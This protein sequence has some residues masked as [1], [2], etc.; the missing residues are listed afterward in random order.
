MECHQTVGVL[1]DWRGAPPRACLK[2]QVPSR[3]GRYQKHRPSRTCLPWRV[4]AKFWKACDGPPSPGSPLPG[5][6]HPPQ[7]P[8]PS[9]GPPA[10]AT[11]AAGALGLS[12][13]PRLGEQL[14]VREPGRE[15]YKVTSGRSLPPRE[16]DPG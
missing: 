16:L 10:W 6:H 15:A 3:K 8:P 5:H 14:V 12:P 1:Q 9:P 13:P 11:P 2:P 4:S 7:S